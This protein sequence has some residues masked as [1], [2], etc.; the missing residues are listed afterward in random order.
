MAVVIRIFIT[1]LF[2]RKQFLF[3]QPFYQIK[4]L[5][6]YI[7]SSFTLVQDKKIQAN[8]LALQK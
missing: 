2:L 3:Q 4:F 5:P 8:F 7:G 1:A 6:I